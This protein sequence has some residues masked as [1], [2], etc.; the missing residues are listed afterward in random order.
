MK[1]WK[2]LEQAVEEYLNLKGISFLKITSYRCFRCGQVQ[3]SK[4]AGFPDYHCP[5]YN[6]Y[7]ECKTGKGVLSKEQRIWKQKIEFNNRNTY[8]LLKDNLDDLLDY[9]GDK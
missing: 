8:I 2:Q 6:L 3:N 1:R 9:F 4:A 7:I 5:E